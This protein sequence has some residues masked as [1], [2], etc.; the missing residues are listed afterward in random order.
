MKNLEFLFAINGID[1]EFITEAADDEK[2]KEAFCAEWGEEDES[3]QTDSD[4]TAEKNEHKNKAVKN[5][6]RKSAKRLLLVAVISALV[7]AT[8]IAVC[9]KKIND[10]DILKNFGDRMLEMFV[11]EKAEYEGIEIIKAGDYI[12]Y[13]NVEDFFDKTNLNIMYPSVLPNEIY[14]EFIQISGAYDPN[15]NYNPEERVVSFVTNKVGPY[16][17]SV[18]TSDGEFELTKGTEIIEINGI[19]CYF[20]NTH[21]QC[22]FIVE[23]ISYCIKAPTYEDVVTIVSGMKK[24]DE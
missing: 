3:E 14:I 11:G 5:I 12:I 7:L 21:T 10:L 17:I 19:E 4:T 20:T 6:C 1:D 23:D 16:S 13:E 24:Y 18:D 9:G 2:L 15:L 22:S 8:G